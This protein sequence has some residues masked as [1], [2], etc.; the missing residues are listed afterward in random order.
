MKLDTPFLAAVV[1]SPFV[2]VTVIGSGE[3]LDVLRFRAPTSEIAAKRVLRVRREYRASAIV[4]EP[5]GVLTSA[6]LPHG[7]RIVRLSLH[8]AIDALV[9][10]PDGAMHTDLFR[11]LIARFPCLR[12]LVTISPHSG[13]IDL[14]DRWKTMT[15]LSVALGVA[16]RFEVPERPRNADPAE[17]QSPHLVHSFNHAICVPCSNEPAPPDPSGFSASSETATGTQPENLSAG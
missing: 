6:L 4:T 9:P 12:R 3:I 8:D 7:V 10:E 14:L 16:A 15:M 5:R 1:R 11:Q 2:A 13:K 17:D